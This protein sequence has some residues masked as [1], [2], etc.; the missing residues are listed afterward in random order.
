[1]NIALLSAA[2]SI[3]T[4]KIANSLAEFGHKV[5]LFAL[6]EHVDKDGNY[7]KSITI[8][9]FKYGGTKSYFYNHFQLR[10]WLSECKIDIIS[11]H[12][13]SGYGTI[14]ALCNFHPYVLSV[15]GSDVY[16]FPYE[17]RLKYILLKYNLKKADALMSTSHCMARQTE[18]FIKDRKIIVTPFGVDTAAFAPS[19][20]TDRDSINIGFIKSV[21]EKYGIE[22]LLR[23]FKK[24][25]D[26]CPD[27]K[28]KLLIYGGGNQMDEM[29]ALA[30]ELKIDSCTTFFGKIP[31]EQVPKAL[32]EMDIFCV[33]STLDSESFGVSAVEAMSC[34]VPCITS[35]VDG[36]SEVMV[37]GETGFIVKR[38]DTDALAEKMQILIN[39]ADLREK[40]GANGRK[41][42]LEMYDWRDNE[43]IIESTIV[44]CYK[45]YKKQ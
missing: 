7:N 1:M 37:D 41:R 19:P 27:K 12:Y 16:D 30:K 6:P 8:K 17:N 25:S 26:T 32:S 18:K 44:S 38:K 20:K 9:Y 31:H 5:Y 29:Q 36:L 33:P 3:H 14:A 42:V 11:A 15:W 4:E 34:A 22:Y 45:N 2:N 24:A 40:L 23:A 43:K 35:D 21:S 28:L 39:D 10:K 13:A